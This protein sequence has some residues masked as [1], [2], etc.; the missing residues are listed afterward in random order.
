MKDSEVL[1]QP[2]AR[3]RVLLTKV[4]EQVSSHYIA[5]EL[6]GG[7]ILL[8]P[9]VVRAKLPEDVLDIH[10]LL[11]EATTK[12]LVSGEKGEPSE[13]WENVIKRTLTA[14]PQT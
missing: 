14:E 11:E 12:S 3:G 6:P 13:L 2:D 8:S 1:I 5:E 9:A 10:P 4:T 7:V